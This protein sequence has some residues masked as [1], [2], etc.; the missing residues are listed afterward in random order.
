MT[1]FMS[2]NKVILLDSQKHKKKKNDLIICNSIK[3][4]RE[5]ERER[6][7][8]SCRGLMRFDLRGMHL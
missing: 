8:E 6:E 4:M 2:R 1:S 7:R 5:R 3:Y